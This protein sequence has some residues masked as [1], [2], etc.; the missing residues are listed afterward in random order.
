[1]A[2]PRMSV[3]QGLLVLGWAETEDAEYSHGD[4][5]RP[6]PGQA[7]SFNQPGH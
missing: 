4:P 2:S 6:L 1:M 7:S 3:P 5:D